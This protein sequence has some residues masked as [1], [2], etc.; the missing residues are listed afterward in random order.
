MNGIEKK[1]VF[2]VSKYLSLPY[3]FKVKENPT[4]ANLMQGCKLGEKDAF[5]FNNRGDSDHKLMFFYDN[6]I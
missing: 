5:M 1:W 6:L 2:S 3:Q 4:M